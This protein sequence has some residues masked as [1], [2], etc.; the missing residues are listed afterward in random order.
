MLLRKVLVVV[1]VTATALGCGLV[2][3]IFFTFSN[4]VMRA[5]AMLPPEN[6][7]RAMQAINIQIVN[8]LFLAV[9][10]GTPLLSALLAVSGALHLSA[11]GSKLLLVGSLLYLLG[12]LAV[13]VA[14]N[15]PL[16]NR[17]AGLNASSFEAHQYWITYHA[18]WVKWNHVR[19]ISAVTALLAFT[20]AI[21][22]IYGRDG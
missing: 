2:G 5:L 10:V 4:F 1:L 17:P 13:T 21:L 20:V 12:A 11:P 16:N 6:G 3:G 8:P 18:E 14:I 22:Q 19:A 7:I 15:I 9:F